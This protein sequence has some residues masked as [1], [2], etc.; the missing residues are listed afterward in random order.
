MQHASLCAKTFM[1]SE[2]PEWSHLQQVAVQQCHPGEHLEWA[3]H[4]RAGMKQKIS[5]QNETINMHDGLNN[6][7][8]IHPSF[9]A[10]FSAPIGPFLPT[11]ARAERTCARTMATC[12]VSPSSTTALSHFYYEAPR[13]T[14]YRLPDFSAG[15][16]STRT[17]MS[18]QVSLPT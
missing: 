5:V 13:N 15:C 1:A 6:R 8:H 3:R 17:R 2:A 18:E 10:C 14:Q 7:A 12:T 16:N 4:A 9:Q 11:V